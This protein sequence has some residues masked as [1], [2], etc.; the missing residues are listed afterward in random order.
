MVWRGPVS[1]VWEG[2]HRIGQTKA[3]PRVTLIGKVGPN[4]PAGR[5]AQKSARPRV[6][7]IRKVAPTGL[8]GALW[9]GR[10]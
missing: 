5:M 4:D 3:F 9:P 1:A 8:D 2:C 7:P 10:G 6:G